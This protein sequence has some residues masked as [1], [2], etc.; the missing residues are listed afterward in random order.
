[1]RRRNRIAALVPDCA[2]RLH[3][4]LALTIAALTLGVASGMALKQVPLSFTGGVANLM[5]H[6]AIVLGLGAI[7]GRLVASSG[8][9]VALGGF[10][11]DHCGPKGLPWA[12]MALGILVGMPV[13]F[14]VGLVLLMPIVAEVARRSGRPPILAGMPLLAGLSI[15]HGMLPP[16]PAPLLAAGP[17]SRR[18]GTDDSVWTGRGATSR[19]AGWAGA[20]LVDDAQVGEARV[21]GAQAAGE[22]STLFSAPSFGGGFSRRDRNGATVGGADAKTETG[23]RAGW[24]AAGSFDH[25]AAHRADLSGQLGGCYGVDGI[26]GQPDSPFCRKPGYRPAHRG[27]GLAGHAGP[28]HSDGPAS[29][30]RTAAPAHQRSRSSQLPTCW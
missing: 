26:G 11:V 2:L 30:A 25:S 23:S 27:T 29:R 17:F 8:G 3:P 6:I 16:H 22:G 4:A 7:L 20:G 18:P 24:S 10:L 28:A 9:A 19:R 14:E 12:L 15:V 21:A 1:M 13:F 5:G